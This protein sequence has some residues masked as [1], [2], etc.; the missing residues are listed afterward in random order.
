[1][2]SVEK[3]NYAFISYSHQDAQMAKWLQRKLESFKLPTEIHNEFEDS[4]YLRPVIRDK[5]D[6]DSGIL[7]DSIVGHLAQSKFLI[8]ICSPHS[9]QSDWV[10]REIRTF[11]DWG[12]I[13]YIIPF[14]VAGEPNAGGGKECLPK[15][16]ID[17]VAAHPDEELLGISVAE[18]G[19]EKAFIRVVSRMLGVSFDELWKRHKRER[20]RR[21]GFA[22][23]GTL[24]VSLF[25][26]T[27]AVPVSLTISLHDSKHKLPMAKNGLLMINGAEYP[28]NSLDTTITIQDY[29]GYYRG[30][31]VE[32]AFKADYYEILSMNERI[33]FGTKQ[34]LEICLKRDSTFAIFSGTIT[35]E[36]EVP[37]QGARVT[38]DNKETLSNADGFFLITFSVDEQSEFKPIKITKPNYH[39]IS[40]ED[41]CPSNNLKY[42]M[43]M[44]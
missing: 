29:P 22:A 19:R 23:V 41:E 33:T 37:I 14:I 25:F 36:N 39:D 7:S 20:H 2:Q 5:T 17:H 3:H 16:L 18:V 6:F 12:R 30:Q 13:E 24:L 32:V 15:S 27:G 38:I 31:S 44:K 34:L 42:I 35:D 8:V 43:H 28:L 4:R 9:A 26:Y 10:S 1:M 11:I 40:R 21:L